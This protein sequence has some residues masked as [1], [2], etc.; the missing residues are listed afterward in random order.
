MPYSR[1][2]GCS[3]KSVYQSG[4]FHGFESIIA[5]D[6]EQRSLWEGI[7]TLNILTEAAVAILPI[8]V[9]WNLQLAWAKKSVVMLAFA[10][11]IL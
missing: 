10:L 7:E 6:G 8:Y 2:L 5:S 9:L 1:N 11:R 3:L 4:E